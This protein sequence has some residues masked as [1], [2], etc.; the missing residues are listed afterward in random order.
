MM[1]KREANILLL[2]DKEREY[3]TLVDAGYKNV[4]WFKSSLRA[5]EYFKNREDELKKFDV[6]LM[7]SRT[8]DYFN[9]QKYNQP[10]TNVTFNSCD[11]E[12]LSF[13]TGNT[14]EDKRLLFF[15]SHPNVSSLGVPEEEFLGVLDVTIPN[16]L[17][18]E[19]IEMPEVESKDALLPESREDV[20]VLYIGF[21]NNNEAV[22]KVFKESGLTNYQFIGKADFTLDDSVESLSDYDLVVVDN[23]CNSK[24]SLM[25]NEFQDYMKDKGKS[26]YFVCY[27]SFYQGEG[28]NKFYLNGFSTENVSNKK[29]LMFSS[30]ETEEDSLRDLMGLVI[31]T[32]CSYNNNFGDGGYPG[33]LELDGICAKKYEKA[34][35]EARLVAEH[36]Y[37]LATIQRYLLDYR[38][39]ISDG[40]NNY[41]LAGQKTEVIQHGVRITFEGLSVDIFEEGLSIAFLVGKREAS[42]LTFKDVDLKNDE[43]FEQFYMEY[44][45]EKGKTSPQM[46]RRYYEYYDPSLKIENLASEEEMKKVSAIYTRMC[47]VLVPIIDG[48]KNPESATEDNKKYSMKYSESNNK[49]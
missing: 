20:K 41:A 18:G 12:K 2:S 38:E 43:S 30:M 36:I 8:V 15:V 37:E 19:V 9:A 1:D 21:E 46:A 14:M 26:I 10:F 24:L 42:R 44:L 27:H 45:S 22:E 4:F 29:R 49:K 5:Y 40:I 13:F 25:G 35:E 33:V 31:N 47:S 11:V 48:I 23:K 3:Q 28:I 16:E 39:L 7:G 17:K 6:I 32:Y 34:C